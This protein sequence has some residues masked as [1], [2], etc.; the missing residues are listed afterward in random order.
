MATI[1]QGVFKAME[2]RCIG[3]HRGGRSVAAVGDPDDPM[4]FY[5]GACNG[6]VWKTDDGGTYWENIS[7]GFFK[8]SAVGAIAVA[9]SDPNVIYAGMGEACIRNDVSSGDGVYK[10]TDK[11]KTWQHVGL[12]D[13]RHIARV[14]IHPKDP[15]LV[16]VAAL[17]HAWAPN[18]ERGVLRS[19]DGGNNW[20][21]VLFVSDKAG[22]IDLSID[23]NNPRILYAATWEVYRN[24]WTISSGGP[25]SRLYKSTDGG[26]TWT[27][28]TD[29][30]GFPKG[31]KGRIGVAV[32][33]ARSDRVW[34]IVEAEEGGL[35]RSDDGG[36]SW[37][38][39]NNTDGRGRPWYHT[40]VFAHPQDPETVWTMD[41]FFYMSTD[42]GRTFGQMPLPHGDHHDLWIDPRNPSRMIEANDGGATI[43]FNGGGSWSTIYNQPTACFYHLAVDNQYPYRVYG[44]QQDNTA[45][46]VPSKS[47]KSAI[48]LS[49]CYMTGTSESG[50]IAVR[51]DNPNIVYSGAIGSS[52]GGGGNLLRSDHALGDHI[53]I[54]TVW[55][56][57]SWGWAPKDEKYRFHWTYPI[58][59]SPHDSDVL[60]CTGNLVFRS[61]NEGKSW[62]SI[63]PDL[64]R[65]DASKLEISGGP[66]TVQGVSGAETYCTIFAF[67][68]SPHEQGVFWAGSDDGLIHISRDGGENWENVTPPDVPEWTTVAFIE[69]SHHDAAT[70]YVAAYRY[71]LDDYNPY[72]YKTRDYGRTW[73]KITSGIGAEDF[74]R[75]IREDPVRQGLLYAGTEF[76]LYVSF[77]DGESW[78][79]LQLNLPV[80]P[81]Y[82]LAVK[83]DE[84][85]ACTHGRSFWILDDVT[86]LRQANE[87]MAQSPAYLFKPK[88]T[89]Q[90]VDPP[91]FAPPPGVP[92]KRN[93]QTDAGGGTAFYI[94]RRADGSSYRSHIDAGD[95]PTRGV[96]VSY[97][98]KEEPEGEVT[99]TFADASGQEIR[100][101]TSAKGEQAPSTDES[102]QKA[103]EQYVPVE[104]GMNK[105]IW[106]MRYT[107]PKALPR[108]AT[109]G[110][111]RGPDQGPEAPPGTYQVWLTVSGQIYNQS[112]EILKD[113]RISASQE[114]LEDRFNTLMQI[115]DKL[116]ETNDAILRVRSIYQ[117][118]EEWEKRGEGRSDAI[119]EAAQTLRGKLSPIEA[120]L[121]QTRIKTKA[122]FMRYPSQLNAKLRAVSSV[123]T[124]STGTPTEQSVDAFGE[125]SGRV[126]V[127]LERLQEVIDKDLEEFGNLVLELEVP[128]IIPMSSA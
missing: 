40:H 32:S 4:T 125:F 57:E 71:K 112:F 63:S 68:E 108:D 114:E 25:E 30:P 120:E 59:I 70:A 51:P 95:N 109:M 124:S 31:L 122:D 115:R 55:P 19:R 45:I 101:F 119:A 50:H 94:R 58:V 10:S 113:P 82:D 39:V 96:I 89:H 62:E 116:S 26:D 2:W 90:D 83:G 73:Q 117:Q 60:Y 88:N 34:A 22:A 11:G 38:L 3:P 86:P 43:T 76:G 80:V 99:L 93:Y 44:T 53:E 20:E 106:D 87:Q 56:E 36:D 84:L 127:H 81:L 123:V 110:G 21:R 85:V 47:D 66:V 78:Q 46:S 103:M 5:F 126:D 33:P 6:G 48:P 17:G 7:D 91:V 121:I 1:D 14:R 105:F 15:D 13:S 97:F 35:Y 18:E 37:E 41:S 98:L 74:T 104:R 77:D 111:F 79:L 61:T 12:A 54:I 65:N 28:L 16:Y 23:A 67:T 42:G 75:V 52:A 9:D 128:S 72:L 100:S 27:A 29:N 92:G 102:Q 107:A 49:D 118:V 8:T 64:T 24:P 69:V